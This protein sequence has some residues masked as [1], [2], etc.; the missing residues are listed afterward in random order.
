MADYDFKVKNGLVVN[1]S[2]IYASGGTTNVGINTTTP[3]ASLAVIG[4]ANVSGNV[5]LGSALTVSG[6]TTVSNLNITNVINVASFNS[7]GLLTTANV[8]SNV[9]NAST[10]NVTGNVNAG[11]FVGTFSGNVTG[12]LVVTGTSNGVVFNDGGAANAVAG[13]TFNKSTNNVTIG[14]NLSVATAFSLSTINSSSNGVYIN[15][16]SIT[17]GNSTVNVTINSTS[18][19]GNVFNSNSALFANNATYFNGYTWA[20]PATLGSTTANSAT[21]TSVNVGANVSVTTSTVTIG[22]STVNSTSNSSGYLVAN[23]SGFANVAPNSLAISN[24][25]T[26]TYL[27]A[28]QLLLAG[29]ATALNASSIATST[30]TFTGN[31]TVVGILANSSLGNPTNVLTSNGA[32][33]YWAPP[34]A[35]SGSVLTNGGTKTNNFNANTNSEYIVDLS[36]SSGNITATLTGPFSNEDKINFFV[37]GNSLTNYQLIVDATTNNFKILGTVQNGTVTS[38]GLLSMKYENST[39][40]F[41]SSFSVAGQSNT[42]ISQSMSNYNALAILNYL[43]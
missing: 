15:T 1:G 24:N 42:T 33:V 30:G 37:I 39:F 28:S 35:L 4:T 16:N 27:T 29:G 31:L 38:S 36:N 14:N 22:N 20:S 26:T 40:G 43:G 32:G 12:N 18:F 19:S 6:L 41:L 17:V 21:F 5:A 3:D 11:Y 9:V 34:P 10:I 8:N 23:S 7:T 13:F 2:L 25:S